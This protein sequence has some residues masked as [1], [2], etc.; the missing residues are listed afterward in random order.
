MT[1]KTKKRLCLIACTALA[2]LSVLT[3]FTGL[4]TAKA[5]SPLPPSVDLPAQSYV[6][7]LNDMYITF[8]IVDNTGD[9]A[10]LNTVIGDFVGDG[11]GIDTLYGLSV[12]S[13]NGTLYNGWYSISPTDIFMRI[14]KPITRDNHLYLAVDYQGA[15]FFMDKG[16]YTDFIR[17]IGIYS[18][19]NGSSTFNRATYT[20]NATFYKPVDDYTLDGNFS[21][22][23]T[24]L[25]KTQT[26]LSGGQNL[27]LYDWDYL[28]KNGFTRN[29]YVLMADYYLVALMPCLDSSIATIDI[30]LDAYYMTAQEWQAFQREALEDFSPT[31]YQY[32]PVP[33]DDIGLGTI[34]SGVSAFLNTEFIPGFKLW[35]FL[36]IGLGCA[37]TGIALKFFLGG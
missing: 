5:D 18:A 35:Y 27:E 21:L 2:V 22:S 3:P 28:E 32:I 4:K 33:V 29:G 30:A 1:S 24:T 11:R 25:V 31:I 14:S 15:P 17:A 36:L 37:V 26:F 16:I 12:E 7:T 34:A 9:S 10:Y 6:S 13:A 8:G 19:Q 20:V 23:S